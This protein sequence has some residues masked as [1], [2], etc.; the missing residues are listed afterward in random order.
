M[1][2]PILIHVYDILVLIYLPFSAAFNQEVEKLGEGLLDGPEDVCVD[3]SG[4]IY[5][6]TRDGWIKKMHKNQS[7]EN[8]KMI[9]GPTLLGLT[10]SIAG[11]IIVCDA[12]RVRPS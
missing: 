5:T 12:D 6:V 2:G 4:A 3:K 1:H 11:D 10:C 7:W 9:A 8:W